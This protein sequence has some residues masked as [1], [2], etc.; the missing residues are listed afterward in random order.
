MRASEALETFTIAKL[1]M[2]AL[3]SLLPRDGCLCVCVLLRPSSREGSE[4]ASAA[5]RI[6][7]GTIRY[8]G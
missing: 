3:F 2:R 1:F 7:Q 5:R 8:N 4:R 6:F